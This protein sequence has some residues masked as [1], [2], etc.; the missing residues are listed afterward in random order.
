MIIQTGPLGKKARRIKE[1][2]PAGILELEDDP[3]IRCHADIVCDVLA[4]C[5]GDELLVRGVLSVELECLC[6]RCGCWF[7]NRVEVPG[8]ACAYPIAESGESI[9]LTRD[10]REDILLGFPSNWLCGNDC[11]G[12]CARCGADLNAGDCGC[13]PDAP[14]GNAWATLDRLLP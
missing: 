7:V 5:I 4:E 1:S 9:D 8:F 13:R 2:L 10:I 6:A 11:R 3:F 12:R 14:A